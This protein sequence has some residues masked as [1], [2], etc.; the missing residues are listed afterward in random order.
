MSPPN[1]H[2]W[3]LSNNLRRATGP[4]CRAASEAGPAL[5]DASRHM[6]SPSAAA[7]CGRFGRLRR[8]TVPIQAVGTM[9]CLVPRRFAE[10]VA[11]LA[12][13]TSSVAARPAQFAI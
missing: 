13:S 3:N 6:T 5:R 11:R 4:R 10:I 8:T 1:I 2:R 9:A 7:R 12:D